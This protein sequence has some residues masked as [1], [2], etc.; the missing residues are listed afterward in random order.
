[1]LK[2]CF[3]S[4]ISRLALALL[5]TSSKEVIKCQCIEMRFAGIFCA[6]RL[7]YENHPLTGRSFRPGTYVL[8][9]VQTRIY[10]LPQRFSPFLTIV[11]HGGEVTVLPVCNPIGFILVETADGH[12]G[13]MPAEVLTPG[14]VLRSTHE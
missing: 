11:P 13:Y 10:T 5:A 2:G 9:H 14:R 8:S 7:A 6:Q 3:F 12:I 1:V 4:K